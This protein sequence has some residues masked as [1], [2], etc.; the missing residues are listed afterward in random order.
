MLSIRLSL[1]FLR[2]LVPRLGGFSPN[3]CYSDVSYGTCMINEVTSLLW[4]PSIVG[5]F[6]VQSK[7]YNDSI[8]MAIYA[9]SLSHARYLFKCQSNKRILQLTVS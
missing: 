6:F 8:N 2:Y 1:T 9:T 4:L 7:H 5:E 3:F